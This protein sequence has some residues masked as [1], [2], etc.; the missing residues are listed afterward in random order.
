MEVRQF[1]GFMGFYRYFIQGFSSV[2]HPLLKLT[3]KATP[4]HWEK[5]QQEAFDDLKA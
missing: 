5:E 1:L 2:A 3:Q 4:W